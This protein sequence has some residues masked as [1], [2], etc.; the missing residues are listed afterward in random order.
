M[1]VPCAPMSIK[2]SANRNSFAQPFRTALLSIPE[3]TP[4]P[5]TDISV[6]VAEPWDT[7]NGRVTLAGDSAHP[8]PPFRGQGGNHAIQDAY[9]FVAAVRKIAGTAN[10]RAELQ[11]KL[12]KD[13]SDEVAKRGAEETVLSLKNGKFLMA[14]DDFKESPYMKQGLNRGGSS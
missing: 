5:Y 13:Y 2:H 8:M 7:R 4:V 11:E 1:R 10:G 9:N 6:W 3:D 14:Y 12:M